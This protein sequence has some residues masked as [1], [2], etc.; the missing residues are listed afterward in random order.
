[1]KTRGSAGSQA[2]TPTAAGDSFVKGHGSPKVAT[3]DSMPKVHPS[4]KLTPK[5]GPVTSRVTPRPL[6]GTPRPPLGTRERYGPVPPRPTSTPPSVHILKH[7]PPASS[8]NFTPFH[9]SGLQKHPTPRLSKGAPR[10]IA[11][12]PGVFSPKSA[13]RVGKPTPAF[14]GTSPRSPRSALPTPSPLV[15]SPAPKVLDS[16]QSP[17]RARNGVRRS[18][19]RS[20]S[21]LSLTSKNHGSD[22]SGITTVTPPGRS[23]SAA[24]EL[25]AS[26]VRTPGTKI[27]GYHTARLGSPSSSLK[28]KL[29]A[30]KV[31]LEGLTKKPVHPNTARGLHAK[32]K[33][34]IDSRASMVTENIIRSAAKRAKGVSFGPALS[35]EQFDKTLPPSTPVKKGA[36]PQEATTPSTSNALLKHRAP[37]PFSR[38]VSGVSQKQTPMFSPSYVTATPSRISGVISL[39]PTPDTNLLDSLN[40]SL[41]SSERP[42][43]FATYSAPAHKQRSPGRTLKPHLRHS[44]GPEATAWQKVSRK[45]AVPRVPHSTPTSPHRT[46][47]IHSGASNQ[48][49]STGFPRISAS[50]SG[51]SRSPLVVHSTDA[52]TN[53]PRRSLVH[54]RLSSAYSRKSP[55]LFSPL[56]TNHLLEK[57][58]GGVLSLDSPR[59]SVG[60]PRASS[61][62]L[63]ESSGWITPTTTS[64]L[65]NNT[66]SRTPSVSGVA[67]LSQ[68]NGVSPPESRNVG[69]PRSSSIPSAERSNNSHSAKRMIGAHRL[70]ETPRSS[71][72]PR[73]P[74]DADLLPSSN[75]SPPTRW[76]HA[77]STKRSASSTPRSTKRT[78]SKTPLTGVRRLMKTPKSSGTPRVSGV[79]DLFQTTDVNV[80]SPHRSVGRPR[81]SS[82][83]QSASSTPRSTKRTV[84]KTPLTGVR[85]LM[86]TPKS[87]GTPRVSGVADLFQT[88]DVN[89]VSPHRSVGRP[90]ASSAKRSASSTPR[91]TK[92]TVSKTPLTGVR[93]LMKTPKSSGTPR[94]SGVADLFQTTDVNVVSPHR[95]VGRPRASSAKRSAS[96]TPRSTKRTVSKTPLTG[97]RRLMKTPKSSGTPRVSGVAD[98]FQTT[99]VNVVSPHRSVGRPRASSAKRSASSTPRSTKRTVS[100]TPLTGVRRLMKTPKS[101]GTPRVS[102][103]ADL[104]QTTDVNVVSP[105]R[106]V[107]RPRAS[108]AKRSASSTPRST[109]RTVSKTPLTGVRRLMKTPKSSG[110]P[111]VSGVADL[112]QT[113]DV[114]V[115]SPHRS[116]GRPRASSAKRSASSTPRSTKRTVS[117]TPLTGVRRLMKTPKSSGTPR[118][119]GVADLFQTTDVNV[120]SPH[121]SV[122]RPRASSAKRS[123]SST[124]RSTK[125]TVSKTPLTGVRRLMKTP[126]SSGT[127]RVSGVA[128]LFQ[129][130]DVN[131]VSPHRSVGR[132]RASSAKR[133]ASSTP[134]STK[135]T[136]SKTP[137][138]GVRRLMKTPKS[139]GTPRVS[140]VADLFQTTDVNVVSPHR[141][142][143][144]PRASSAKQSASSTPRS[145]KRTFSKT[146]LTGVRRLM[147]TPKSSGTPRVSGV[148]DL[149]QTTD[150]NVVSPHRSVGRPR[151]SSSANDKSG[152]KDN[153]IAAVPAGVVRARRRQVGVDH[154]SIS[155][156]DEVPSVSKES[157]MR[158]CRGKLNNKKIPKSVGKSKTVIGDLDSDVSSKEPKSMGGNTNGN[159]SVITDHRSS[160]LPSSL[161]SVMGSRRRGRTAEVPGFVEEHSPV[162]KKR[163]LRGG[164]Q[165]SRSVSK[166]V[167]KDTP[168]IPDAKPTIARQT[169]SRVQLGTKNVDSK[170]PKLSSPARGKRI[171]RPERLVAAKVSTPGSENKLGVLAAGT[172]RRQ[173]DASQHSP[174]NSKDVSTVHPPSTKRRAVTTVIDKKESPRSA[175]ANASSKSSKVL[176]QK[177]SVTP[178]SNRPVVDTLQ[179]KLLKLSN[180]VWKKNG[181][182][183]L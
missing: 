103:V 140:G 143:G 148:A 89:V 42:I 22:R 11:Q 84:S 45:Q 173:L 33:R 114:N 144:R 3:P 156:G 28:D 119:S 113:T 67:A 13:T 118:V 55:L 179:G 123:A 29:K 96:S 175:S 61:V 58:P 23:S 43:S 56:S 104:F 8:P 60:R 17:H 36:I 151:A 66:K 168:G 57:D 1:M 180:R 21:R 9:P 130:T 78:V 154:R 81:A 82:A 73:I 164:V 177:V 101:S 128:D 109:K 10:K 131:V 83:K 147:K 87:S 124:P 20:T 135:R 97:V 176:L 63:E 88:T 32:I 106:S 76:S 117:K 166:S 34:P 65:S 14:S 85:R 162:R 18:N 174:V 94:V 86:K 44:F 112:F 47:T 105:H 46:A 80:V 183:R 126:K 41:K 142:V 182:A 27:S 53:S 54:P 145:T 74:P 98:L 172:K 26:P 49:R 108:S 52:K 62:P 48:D 38:S 91:S 25:A 165:S 31:S 6:S 39:P 110:T 111:R 4:R 163:N 120:V 30:N 72:T 146:P 167:L 160:T 133:S 107:G 125:R 5:P 16:R 121:R 155:V 134:R 136:V 137:L 93:R 69:R 150:V 178:L 181:L 19:V 100:K 90:R 7:T 37:T 12:S 64:R 59:H 79:A 68:M 127:P 115:V 95:S 15:R 50:F 71:I 138:T 139:S 51:K 92:R 40:G 161:V 2:N 169:R 75:L 158:S 99:D 24:T 171:I 102:G 149:F 122:G 152:M 153:L 170:G 35:P 116:V 159:S 141:S 70:K 132:P 129:T 157:R 77:S